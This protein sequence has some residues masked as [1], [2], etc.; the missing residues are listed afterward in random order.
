[1]MLPAELT[2]VVPCYNEAANVRPLVAALDKALVGLMWEVVFVDD[3]SPDGTADIVSEVAA[4]D[5]RVRVI[6][7]VGRR[8]LSSAVIEGCLSS[9]APVVSV[10]DGDLQHDET[11]LPGMVRR[12]IDGD[13]D[14]VVAS[15][16]VEGG[17]SAGLDGRWR[18]LL[19]QGGIRLA[20]SILPCRLTDPMS[21]FFAVRRSVFLAAVPRLAGSGFKILL[22]LVLSV[23]PT[24]QV[25]EV[26]AIFKPR[27]AGESKLGPVV[28]LQFA[29][30]LV[31]RLCGGWLP[32]RFVVFAVVGLIGIVV[33]IAAMELARMGGLTFE[34]AQVVG[35]ICAILANFQLNNRLTYHDK[36]LKGRRWWPGFLIFLIGC[37]LGNAANIGVA[38]MLFD[39]GGHWTRS[40]AAGALIGVVW[41]YA[42]AS[43]L[44][45]R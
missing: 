1:M 4:V 18:H 3:N 45:W 24:T 31:E 8:G 22:E 29:G 20:Q 43:T 30:M 14:I 40:S 36:R 10:M 34:K 27:V 5:P 42:V 25:T 37:G 21:G 41:N 17:D 26:P 12:I 44:V 9:S 13:A 28:M 6:R 19:S 38:Q 23:P 16:H 32:T 33:N 35:T 15:R 7:R 11:A 39:Q 2:V